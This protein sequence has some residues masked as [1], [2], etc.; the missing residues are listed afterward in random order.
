MAG[1]ERFNLQ[2]AKKD[3]LASALSAG[4]TS[5]TLT[6]GNFTAFTDD[7]L[8]IDYDVSNKIEVVKCTVSSTAVSSMTRGQ[9]GTSDQDHDAGAKVGYMFVPDHLDVFPVA[10]DRQNNTTNTAVSQQK[11]CNGWGF[12]EGEDD[13][14]AKDTVTFPVTFDDIPIVL[15]TFVG[16]A[17]STPTSLDDF[18]T[19]RGG[20]TATTEDITSSS[21][22]AVLSAVSTTGENPSNLASGTYYGYTW[23]AIGQKAI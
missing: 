14:Q 23:I 5:A 16:T 15:A 22:E 10:T 12:V 9:F 4:A 18:T 7:Y 13:K 6:S 2:V 11:I 20:I 17:A 19:A 8:V 1:Q 21:F 3:T